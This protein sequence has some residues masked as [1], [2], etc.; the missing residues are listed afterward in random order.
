MKSPGTNELRIPWFSLACLLI[1]LAL[2]PYA[3]SFRPYAPHAIDS[4]HPY[5]ATLIL[6]GL[7]ATN[8][9][10]AEFIVTCFRRRSDV[11]AITPFAAAFLACAVVGWRSYPY[12]ANGVYQ[13]GIGAFPLMDQDPKGLIP[14][15]WIGELW[16]L[17]VLLLYV[18]CYVALPALG[19]AAVVALL[20]HRFIVGGMTILCISITLILMLGFSPD[21]LT[22]LM[23]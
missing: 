20:R 17:P 16:R 7:I 18:L 11:I 8:A 1:L 9:A 21:Y 6:L 14:M 10:F 3:M 22:W 5:R 2:A 13:V 23:D 4:L 19:I 12:W 15:V